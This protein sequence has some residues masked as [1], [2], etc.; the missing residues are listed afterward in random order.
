MTIQP[1][2]LF[3]VSSGGSKKCEAQN[4]NGKT[5]NVLVNRGGVSHKTGIENIPATVLDTDLMLVNRGGASFKATGAEV[6]TLFPQ[7]PAGGTDVI[8]DVVDSGSTST[9]TLASDKNLNTFTPGDAIKMVDTNGDTAAY[10]PITS[11]LTAATP[12]TIDGAWASATPPENIRYR[13]AT[14]GNG[15]FVAVADGGTRR[16]AY[17]DDGINWDPADAAVDI[18]WQGITFGD[19]KFVAVGK[20]GSNGGMYSTDGIDWT[21]TT[22][23][24]MLQSADWY[25][26][27]YGGDKFVAVSNKVNYPVAYSDDGITWRVDAIAGPGSNKFRGIA[28]GNGKFVI[29]GDPKIFSSTD[30]INWKPSSGVS[31]NNWQS[32]AYGNGKF[33]AVADTAITYSTDGVNWTNPPFSSDFRQSWFGVTY[34]DGKFVAVSVDGSPSQSMYSTD[35]ITWTKVTTQSSS[36]YEL[37][38]GGDKFVAVG[39]SAIMYSLTGTGADEDITTLALTPTSKDLKY[40]NPGDKVTQAANF[41]TVKSVGTDELVLRDTAA[42]GWTATTTIDTRTGWYGLAYGAGKFVALAYNSTTPR[43][44]VM[45]SPDGITWTG[46]YNN[47]MATKGWDALVYANGKFVAVAQEGSPRSA[48]SLDGITWTA[49]SSIYNYLYTGLAYGNNTWVAATMHTGTVAFSTDDG[50]YWLTISEVFGSGKVMGSGCVAFGDGKFVLMLGGTAAAPQGSSAISTDGQAWTAYSLPSEV[51]TVA[52][53]DITYGDGKFVAVGNWQSAATSQMIYSFD[54]ITWLTGSGA[55]S[56][57][58]VSVVY[59]DNKFVAGASGVGGTAWSTDG[60]TWNAEGTTI[61][62]SNGWRALAYGDGKFVAVGLTDTT[63]GMYSETGTGVDEIS[64]WTTSVGQAAELDKPLSG[65]GTYDSHTG[66]V[67]TVGNSNTEWVDNDNQRGDAYYATTATTR[68]SLQKALTVSDYGVM[69]AKARAYPV[70]GPWSNDS[71]DKP[72]RRKK[73]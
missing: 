55:G 20:D 68:L 32:V 24:F 38:Y 47:D 1:S 73:K 48:Y 23:P 17:S 21:P 61:T 72:K 14:Y 3:L 59:A 56:V 35:G 58:Y 4:L 40:F 64:D 52:W 34:G 43:Y 42:E 13:S 2:D 51:Q 31:T 57:S 30:G 53:S 15:K 27:V 67:M 8:T 25:N 12:G 62:Q 69:E 29:C 46:I 45:T 5:G 10:V 54:G 63:V 39:T 37:V 7:G 44:S 65:A 6:Q 41:G 50:D 16:V 11:A 70:A 60:I 33:V 28:Y 18:Q 22:M 9:L 71:T 19:G 66:S 49:A 36:W 26:V